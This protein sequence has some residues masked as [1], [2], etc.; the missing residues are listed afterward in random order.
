VS[1]QQPLTVPV[2]DVGTRPLF[3]SGSSIFCLVDE[4]DFDWASQWKWKVVGS[5][6]CRKTYFVRTTRWKG[7]HVSIWLHKEICLRANGLPP[8]D[9]AT[10]ADHL[11][12]DSLVNRRSNLRWADMFQNFEN[13]NGV[14][15]M[16]LRIAIATRDP[17]RPI[18]ARFSAR[19][20]RLCGSREWIPWS[21]D[22]APPTSGER[23]I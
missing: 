17:S 12:G 1:V 4:W 11:N 23:P 21:I 8:N 16:Q 2:V 13:R 9:E 10:V 20:E 18:G 3:A 5:K 19:K 14:A 7:R 6:R 15:A 22:D